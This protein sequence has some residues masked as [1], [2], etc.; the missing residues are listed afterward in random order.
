MIIGGLRRTTVGITTYPQPRVP[1]SLTPADSFYT[2]WL[3][4]DGDLSYDDGEADSSGLAMPETKSGISGFKLPLGVTFGISGVVTGP[5]SMAIVAD[6]VDFSGN[7]D[8]S[9]NGRGEAAS[10][11]VVYVTGENGTIYSVTVT[12]L[13]AVRSWRWEDNQWK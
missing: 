4:V 6:G 12:K 8:V 2:I 10:A 3:D 1:G 11:G 13:G 7:D 5:D 9:F